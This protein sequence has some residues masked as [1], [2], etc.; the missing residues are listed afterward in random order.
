MTVFR[1]G[2]PACNSEIWQ[3]K[4]FLTWCPIF[5]YLFIFLVCL[6]TVSGTTMRS[7]VTGCGH[8]WPLT[9]QRGRTRKITTVG[10]SSPKKMTKL[11]DRWVIF[12]PAGS[13]LSG[14]KSPIMAEVSLAQTQMLSTQTHAYTP[15]PRSSRTVFH[16]AIP[17]SCVRAVTEAGGFASKEP[18]N[19]TFSCQLLPLK[20]IP[21]LQNRLFLYTICMSLTW[22]CLYFHRKLL[23]RW[24]EKPTG[25]SACLMC[26][27]WF[28]F[29]RGGGTSFNLIPRD[30]R[31]SRSYDSKDR[32]DPS[33]LTP[34]HSGCLRIRR[35]RNI[36]KDQSV[37]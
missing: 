20:W 36:W 7:H 18:D 12:I 14:C 15:Q 21:K 24:Q 27:R 8:Q 19:K 11:E 25:R 1:L 16:P 35:S 10:R 5:I 28:F 32:T 30:T 3:H 9:I 13:Q 17:H 34:L 4:P 33:F 2:L 22:F 37:T 29:W 26:L 23:S 6:G 31:T